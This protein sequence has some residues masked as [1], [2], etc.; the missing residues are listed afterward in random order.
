MVGNKTDLK[1][2]RS[3]ETQIGLDKAKSFSMPFMETSAAESLN[4]DEAFKI[5]IL[6]ISFF[7]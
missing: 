6:G 5:I 7:K 2:L 4:V 1:H 3:V